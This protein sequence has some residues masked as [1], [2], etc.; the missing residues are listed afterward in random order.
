MIPIN[1]RARNSTLF[2]LFDRIHPS[3][4]DITLFHE[5]LNKADQPFRLQ[6][7]RPIPAAQLPQGAE[8]RPGMVTDLF[9]NN[10]VLL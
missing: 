6:V 7:G 3:L 9:A 10:P 1:I 8:A 5:V 2:Y 4:R